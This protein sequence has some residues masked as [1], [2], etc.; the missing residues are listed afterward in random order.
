MRPRREP[1]DHVAKVV[2]AEVGPA[3]PYQDHQHGRPDGHGDTLART[4]RSGFP[5]WEGST[6]KPCHGRSARVLY[7]ALWITPQVM[8]APLLPVGS[9]T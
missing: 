8:R 2:S 7:R 4:H 6:G 1:A 9:V 3:E 5:V